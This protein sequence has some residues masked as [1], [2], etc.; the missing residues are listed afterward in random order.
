MFHG[1]KRYLITH[2]QYEITGSMGYYPILLESNF[3]QFFYLWKEEIP[4]WSRLPHYH[5]K[6]KQRSFLLTIRTTPVLEGDAIVAE[7]PLNFLWIGIILYIA[8]IQQIVVLLYLVVEFRVL[9]ASCKKKLYLLMAVPY[10]CW[11]LF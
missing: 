4:H 5:K 11:F 8:I 2:S 3:Y 9:L 7:C 6:I 10:D 1:R